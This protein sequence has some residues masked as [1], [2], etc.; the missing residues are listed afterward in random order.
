MLRQANH[1]SPIGVNNQEIPN[2]PILDPSL[3][4]RNHLIPFA[5]EAAPPRKPTLAP[6]PPPP[7]TVSPLPASPNLHPFV[8]PLLGSAAKHIFRSRTQEVIHSKSRPILAGNPTNP[9]NPSRSRTP[10]RAFVVAQAGTY[11]FNVASQDGW[12]FGPGGLP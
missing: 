2:E 11:T 1:G 9:E 3:K 5:N 10:T 6:G 12:I 8:G 7:E 4:K